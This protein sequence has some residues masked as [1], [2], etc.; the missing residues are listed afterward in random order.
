MMCAQTFV[1][2]AEHK[3]EFGFSG[4]SMS[5]RNLS[6]TAESFFVLIESAICLETP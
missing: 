1:H 3:L 6:D 4:N 5:L 2:D